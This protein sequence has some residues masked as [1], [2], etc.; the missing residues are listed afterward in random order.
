MLRS[1]Y[2]YRPK[3]YIYFFFANWYTKFTSGERKYIS[4]FKIDFEEMQNV[5]VFL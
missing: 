5:L 1:V 3:E 4:N 2:V